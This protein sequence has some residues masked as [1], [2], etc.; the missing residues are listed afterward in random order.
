[1]LIAVRNDVMKS[2]QRKQVPWEHSALTGRFFFSPAARTTE[3]GTIAPARLSE[4]AEAWDRAKDATSI[5]VLEAFITRYKDTFYADL[6][7]ARSD[8]LKRQQVVVAAPPRVLTPAPAKT[9]EPAVPAVAVTPTPSSCG[10][11]LALVGKERRCLKPKDSFRDCTE[12]PEMMVIPAGQFMM[13]SPADEKD[14]GDAEGPQ[15]TVTIAEPFC[16]G[17]V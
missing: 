1:M 6:A 11:V 12:C 10:G 9:A 16:R 2:T 5:A 17:Q 8:D 13:G 14:R 7:R 15:R 4:A 3:P